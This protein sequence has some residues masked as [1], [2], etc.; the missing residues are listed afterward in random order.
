MELLVLLAFV[1]VDMSDWQFVYAYV[2][3]LYL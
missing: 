2:L 1:F 3:C